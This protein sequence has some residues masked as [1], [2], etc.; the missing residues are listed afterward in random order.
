MRKSRGGICKRYGF[1]ENFA[2]GRQSR[3]A[4]K[5]YKSGLL[6]WQGLIPMRQVEPKPNC[7]AIIAENSYL[8]E[9]PDGVKYSVSIG[10]KVVESG[11][12]P[13]KIYTEQIV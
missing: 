2:D 12:G 11:E 3:I 13:V 10:G 7:V 4:R 9:V 6:V 5:D 8:Y 1:R